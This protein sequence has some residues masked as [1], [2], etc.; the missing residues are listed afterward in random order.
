MFDNNQPPADQPGVVQP[1]LRFKVGDREYDPATAAVKIE[2]ADKH[3]STLEQELKALREQLTLT[4]AQKKAL[5]A[6]SHTP[7]ATPP[8][9]TGQAPAIDVEDLLA[10][11]EQRVYESL[12][13]KQQDELASKNLNEATELAKTV[14]GDAYQQELLKRGAELGMSKDDITA[15]AS[16]KPEAFKRLFGLAQQLPKGSPVPASQYNYK[17][18]PSD[19]L[20]TVAA[21]ASLDRKASNRQRTEAIAAALANA[22]F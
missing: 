2:H 6:L 9:P 19:D 1:E 21:K 15:F 16:T 18:S 3:I 22:K 11:A 14:L 13:R 10:K 7:P 4:E 8:A 17:P 12:T 5:E 20:I